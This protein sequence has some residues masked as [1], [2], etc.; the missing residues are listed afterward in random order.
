MSCEFQFCQLVIVD[1]L[2]STIASI[3]FPVVDDLQGYFVM[4]PITS[5]KSL[6]SVATFLMGLEIF[7]HASIPTKSGRFCSPQ[8][9]VKLNTYISPNFQSIQVDRYIYI[10][11]HVYIY[12]DTLN[13]NGHV[14][15]GFL[16]FWHT[17]KIYGGPFFED[18][19]DA[20]ES[21]VMCCLMRLHSNTP[22]NHSLPRRRVVFFCL[23]RRQRRRHVGASGHP[24]HQHQ[25]KYDGDFTLFNLHLRSRTSRTARKSMPFGLDTSSFPPPLSVLP[26]KTRAKQR[27]APC[28]NNWSLG[29]NNWSPVDMYSSL[30]RRPML[31][32][33]STIQETHVQGICVTVDGS[34]IL[35]HMGCIKPC[36]EWDKLPTST[37]AG[38][39][40]HQQY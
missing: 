21:C 36:R 4:H 8:P 17:K 22:G 32:M 11:I 33:I 24:H 26:T 27:M 38:F 6:R 18:P 40:N 37:G 15:K 23:S 12:I 25:P 7:E 16:N 39:L 2:E 10:C 5:V 13:I 9:V 29:L 31:S 19:E 3:N 14:K 34:D 20:A 30:S 1:G 28:S 35:H